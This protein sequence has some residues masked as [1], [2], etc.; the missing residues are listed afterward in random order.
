MKVDL[1][2]I[3]L[4]FLTDS[5]RREKMSDDFQKNFQIIFQILD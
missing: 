2:K 5:V 1:N 3:K 4:T